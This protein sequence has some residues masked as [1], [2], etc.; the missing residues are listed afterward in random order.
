MI[1]REKGTFKSQ[2]GTGLFFES[3]FSDA[4]RA[5]VGVVHGYAE[6]SGRFRKTV[7]HLASEN[8]AVHAFD[9]RGHGLSEGRRGHCN[10]FSQY[11]DDLDV[12]WG[13]LRAVS[14]QRKTFLLAHSHGALVTLDWWVKRS[15][16]GLSGL[17]LSS[18]WLKLGLRP[19]VLKVF[20]AKLMGNIIPWLPVSHGLR[21]EDA[22]RDLEV[23]R[24][25]EKDPLYNPNATPRWYTQALAA[26]KEVVSQAAKVTVPVLMLCG[27]ADRIASVPTSREY[28]QALGS[29]DK[30]YRE[31]PGMRHELLNELGK[32]QVWDEIA[33]WIKSRL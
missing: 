32:E 17:V 19:P 14:G 29:S 6:H 30:Q 16:R 23:Q 1:R 22:S 10:R 13:R 9:C 31:F 8:L 12:F 27:E 4:P 26:Q 25:I 15:P 33:G 5:H 21:P 28:F 11:L 18:P 24:A 2:D 3:T 20:M 7:D